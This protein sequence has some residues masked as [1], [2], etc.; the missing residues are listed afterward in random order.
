[1]FLINFD[2]TTRFLNLFII[3]I[4]NNFWVFYY[5]NLIRDYLLQN[6]K[7]KSWKTTSNFFSHSALSKRIFNRFTKF[8]TRTTVV[9][10]VYWI[11]FA[12]HALVQRKQ[13][14][15]PE[16]SCRNE[17]FHI[18]LS[19]MWVR[20][21]YFTP[22]AWCSPH[23]CTTSPGRNFISKSCYQEC[24]VEMAYYISYYRKYW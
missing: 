16:R 2:A 11:F 13:W 18:M 5:R 9:K 14:I 1:M 7:G 22:V 17:V 20:C 3:N 12:L 10:P 6:D 4:V 19:Q 15:F 21:T 24:L 8:V 23:L